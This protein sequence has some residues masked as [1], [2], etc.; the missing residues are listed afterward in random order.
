MMA[1]LCPKEFLAVILVLAFNSHPVEPH[2][3]DHR[4]HCISAALCP[5]YCSLLFLIVP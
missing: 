5:P 1:P 3:K 4:E 2:V